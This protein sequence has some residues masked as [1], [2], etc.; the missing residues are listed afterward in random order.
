MRFQWSNHLQI[1][2]FWSFVLFGSILMM[3]YL[4]VWYQK[5]FIVQIPHG[6]EFGNDLKNRHKKMRYHLS[7]LTWD[8]ALQKMPFCRQHNFS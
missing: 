5:G 8:L 3:Q 1:L 6:A 2:E 7:L 4:T